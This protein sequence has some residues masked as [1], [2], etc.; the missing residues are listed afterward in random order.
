MKNGDEREVYAGIVVGV[1]AIFLLMATGCA[2]PV[3]PSGPVALEPLNEIS[4]AETYFAGGERIAHPRWV[5]FGMREAA[6]N[7]IY[8]EC[9]IH[10]GNMFAFFKPL[11]PFDDL[12][13]DKQMVRI[14]GAEGGTF[15]LSSGGGMPADKSLLEA[16]AVRADVRDRE[17][18]SAGQR[19]RYYIGNNLPT[20]LG[21]LTTTGLGAL[22]GYV[23]KSDSGGGTTINGDGNNVNTG[24]QS[25]SQREDRRETT[26]TSG[27]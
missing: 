22:G 9:R 15:A 12:P 14:F 25:D 7:V 16:V 18:N 17:E 1:V 11:T 6:P 13:I 19:A 20:W 5:S 10:V 3:E 23:L 4:Y 8:G 24:E 21:G 27:R 2:T 26:T